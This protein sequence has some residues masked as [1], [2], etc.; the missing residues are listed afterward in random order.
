MSENFEKPQA[1]KI[2]KIS[3]PD[4]DAHNWV[5]LLVENGFSQPEIDAIMSHLNETY[6]EKIE[7][8][9]IEKEFMKIRDNLKEKK[10]HKLSDVEALAIKQGIASRFK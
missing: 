7:Q 4:D 9:E 2:T 8:S 10:G 3:V 6:R 1:E 5:N